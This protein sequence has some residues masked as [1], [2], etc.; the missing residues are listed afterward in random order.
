MKNLLLTSS[1][2]L[3]GGLICKVTQLLLI[4]FLKKTK[5]PTKFLGRAKLCGER[6]GSLLPPKLCLGGSRQEL[7]RL[8][9]GL[10]LGRVLGVSMARPWRACLPTGSAV[11]LEQLATPVRLFHCPRSS[12]STGS[13]HRGSP[14]GH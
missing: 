13:L 1:G 3:K 4:F 12:H 10:G 9:L 6:K 14:G 5:Q 8:G 11:R 7:A 2:F